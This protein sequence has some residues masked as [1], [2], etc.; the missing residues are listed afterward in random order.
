MILLNQY[1]VLDKN[2]EEHDF[3]QLTLYAFNRADTLQ[4][5]NFF[6][7]LFQNSDAYGAFHDATLSSGFLS[8]PFTIKLGND[9]FDT[10]GISYVSSYPEMSGNGNITNL[11]KLFFQDCIRKH[12]SV[13]YLA[14]FAFPFYRRFGYEEVF[15]R[16]HYQLTNIDVPCVIIPQ[17]LTALTSKIKR[18]SF[19]DVAQL[20]TNFHNNHP[21]NLGGGI[22]RNDW[23]TNY[24]VSKHTD[25]EVALSYTDNQIDG[26]LIYTRNKN[27]E[28]N[29][30]EF[31]YTSKTALWS[32]LSFVAQHRTA[33]KTFN[34]VSGNPI[35][36]L[37]LFP[38]P[39]VKKTLSVST[40]S[41][42]M[43]RIIDLQFFLQN[44][45]VNHSIEDNFIIDVKDDFLG[46]NNGQW[47]INIAKGHITLSKS[48][49]VTDKVI[50][51]NIEQLTKIVFGY[52][53]PDQLLDAA[54]NEADI[55][56]L[57][58]LCKTG[59]VPMLWDYF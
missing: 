57:T 51:I 59:V 58:N 1:R 25:W 22:Q 16:T 36:R 50:H 54:Y 44:F 10:R 26:Y 43:A 56:H 23:W 20:I 34:Y 55:H 42:M 5:Q 31:F 8:I 35:P 2:S 4:R 40:E 3:Y 11:M 12:I 37:D 14:P 24:L 18:S 29:I 45:H 53:K 28:F 38:D 19:K 13:S 15:D 6:H 52:C 33:Y 9:S 48:N 41:Y 39:H 21:R 46:Q 47:T 7:Q 32:L 49:T 17:D 27:I 30:Q